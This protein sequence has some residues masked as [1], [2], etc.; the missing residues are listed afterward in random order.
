MLAKIKA[1]FAANH[2]ALAAL[3]T[4]LITAIASA[5]ALTGADHTTALITAATTA[6]FGFIHLAFPK[7]AI[8]VPAQTIPAKES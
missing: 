2:V 5:A 1:F 7:V 3:L 8:A 6:L 4:S